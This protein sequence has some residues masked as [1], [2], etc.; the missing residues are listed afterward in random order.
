MT[1]PHAEN[2]GADEGVGRTALGVAMARAQES[3]SQCPLFTDPFSHLF[4]DAAAAMTPR[5]S[6]Q[7]Q[8]SATSYAA[9]RTKWFDDYFLSASAAG[10]AQ[11]VMIA[12]ELDTR[13]WRLPWLPDT[14]VYE[15]DRPKLLQFK[16]ETLKVSGAQPNTAYVPVPAD[17]HDDWPQALR[18]AGFDPCEPTAWSVEGLLP[19]ISTAAQ[20]RLFE[21]IGL[22]S[23]RGSRIAVEAGLPPDGAD[24]A[25]WLCAQRW[26]VTSIDAAELFSR[27]HR[28]AAPGGDE[29]LGRNIFVEGRLL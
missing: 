6:E 17:L 1:L 13:A 28:A 23:A 8:C 3:S 15:V 4:V 10:L 27:Y 29:S 9:T 11:V 26:E 5:L 20:H 21:R 22:Y 25:A 2:W 7:Q 24:V 12:A 18:D 14:V 19:C 16:V